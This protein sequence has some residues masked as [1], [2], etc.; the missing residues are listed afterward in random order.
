MRHRGPSPA[1]DGGGDYTPALTTLSTRTFA[2][3]STR[4]VSVQ[5]IQPGQEDDAVNSPVGNDGAVVRHGTALK[6]GA[7]T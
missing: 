6:V 7:S 3:D 1:P 5:R 4:V 2:V